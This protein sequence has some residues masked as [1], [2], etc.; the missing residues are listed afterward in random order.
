METP[1]IDLLGQN[2]HYVR[3]GRGGGHSRG[4]L[5]ADKQ[6]GQAGGPPA[7]PTALSCVVE[8]TCLWAR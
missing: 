5:W 8:E 7:P 2:F 1:R 4:T 3:R 6:P